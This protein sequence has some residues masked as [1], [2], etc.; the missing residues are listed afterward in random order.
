[1]SDKVP[2]SREGYDKLVKELEIMKTTKRRAI[3][4]DIAKARAFGDLKENAEYDAAKNNQA[5]NE[6][7]IANAQD[8]L[9]RVQIIDESKIPN[10]QVLIGATALLKD[11]KTN[12][13]FSYTIVPQDEANF[14]E[15]KISITAPIAK[16]LLGLKVGDTA[17]IKIPAGILKYK[18]LK[19][20]R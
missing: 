5:M 11:L 4:Q 6:R 8:K 13:E 12:D 15:G 10:D 14:D 7:N 9:T 18:I 20:T 16:G 1:M 19:I 3:A 17:E 2:M